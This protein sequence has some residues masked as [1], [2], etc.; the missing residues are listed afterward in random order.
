M[1]SKKYLKTLG[2]TD[3]RDILKKNNDIKNV[4]Y[5]HFHAKN[6]ETIDGTEFRLLDVGELYEKR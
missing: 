1:K 5:G 2:N 4:Y 6:T 3:L